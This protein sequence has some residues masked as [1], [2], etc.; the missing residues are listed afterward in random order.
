MIGSVTYAICSI[1]CALSINVYFLILARIFQGIGAG[2][3]TSVSMAIIKDS[4]SGKK[5][6]PYWLFAQSVS[7]VAP[8]ICS[9]NRRPNYKIFK[10]ERCF[11]DLGTNQYNKL[12]AN[13]V[14]SGKFK[15]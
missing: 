4:F 12:I 11:L 3:I 1:A 13:A 6:S 10:L 8:M 14:I 9:C 7:G 15:G 5:E 2:G